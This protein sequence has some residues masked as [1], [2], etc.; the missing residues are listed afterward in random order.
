MVR[1]DRKD[2]PS[3]GEQ[4]IRLRLPAEP[5]APRMGRRQMEQLE[6]YADR[7]VVDEIQ[8]LVSEL[9]TNSLKHAGLREGD[10]IHVNVD[11][12]PQAIR[13]SVQDPGPGFRAP[14]LPPKAN[15]S[16]WGLLL[17]ERI[18]DEWGV[19]R[20]RGDRTEVWFEVARSAR[21]P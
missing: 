1:N 3:Q 10:S 13:V 20:R 8:L 18:A 15:A 14:V 4:R 17:V 21:R 6:R 7:A 9:I 5:I 12:N 16:G 11:V 19:H 2:S